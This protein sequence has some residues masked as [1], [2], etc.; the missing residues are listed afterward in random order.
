MIAFKGDRMIQRS[1]TIRSLSRGLSVL[2]V[3]ARLKFATAAV[4]AAA[5][6]LPRPTVYRILDTLSVAG[7]VHRAENSD[8]FHLTGALK[9]L[10][11]GFDIDAEATDVAAPILADLSRRLVWPIDFATYEGGAMVVRYSTHAISPKSLISK[12]VVGQHLPMLRTAP[13]LCFLA[14]LPREDVTAVLA[15]TPGTPKPDRL[16]WRTLREA[17]TRGYAFRDGGTVMPNTSSIAVPVRWRERPVACINLMFIRSAMTI[18]RAAQLY[19]DDLQAAATTIEE[20]L[21][22]QN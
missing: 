7:Y 6:G 19:L 18:E 5:A 21:R 22:A 3:L 15:Q 10:A 8:V 17:R 13:G 11:R 2:E 12:A 16:L 4:I 14:H 9:S 20:Q 1:D